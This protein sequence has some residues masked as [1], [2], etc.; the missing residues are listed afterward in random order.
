M[1]SWE[2]QLRWQPLQLWISLKPASTVSAEGRLKDCASSLRHVVWT[3]QFFPCY[4]S[5][6]LP[7]FYSSRNRREKIILL[8]QKHG[9][10]LGQETDS[11]ECACWQV[12]F[13]RPGWRNWHSNLLWENSLTWDLIVQEA[14]YSLWNSR[15]KI[16]SLS[17]HNFYVKNNRNVTFGILT[18]RNLIRTVRYNPVLLTNS[19]VYH[20]PQ[21][22]LCFLGQSIQL[23]SQTSPAG[24]FIPKHF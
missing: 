4:T 15:I 21:I 9:S 18:V 3:S 23:F 1:T 19:A 12:C 5:P 11:F 16:L 20:L 8:D 10:R 14:I 24:G 7:K 6:F 17:P 22:S 2:N 13:M